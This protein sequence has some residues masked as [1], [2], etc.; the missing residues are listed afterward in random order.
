MPFSIL[1]RF[2]RADVPGQPR[3]EPA[4]APDGTAETFAG[5]PGS[6]FVPI[7]RPQMLKD[8]AEILRR[9]RLCYGREPQQFEQDIMAVVTRYA[10]FVNALPATASNY[11]S[12]PGGLFRLGL[13]TAF[14][15]LQATDAQIFEGRGTI[16]QRRHLEPRWRHATF[17]AGLCATLQPTL[18]TVSVV[19]P[20]DSCWPS[21]LLPLSDWLE[22]YPNARFRMIW[23]TAGSVD[24]VQ[25][26]YALPH[27]VPPSVLEY[28]A[29]RNDVVVPTMLATLSRLPLANP[30]STMAALV[31]RAAVLSIARE[32]R[33]MA[34]TQGT[35]LQGDHLGRLLVDIMHDLAHG[36]ASWVPNS[37]KAR[38]WHAQDG[39][40]VVWPGAFQ[41]ICSYADH[42]RLHGLPSDAH[43]AVPALE[44]AGMI[45]RA[46][47]GPL[48]SLRPAGANG[49]LTGLK[50]AFPELVL[51]AQL[52]TC[53]PLPPLCPQ[54]APTEATQSEMAPTT[55]P[56]KPEETP[57]KPQADVPPEQLQ[58]PLA[59]RHPSKSH[60]DAATPAEPDALP[61]GAPALVNSMRL[62]PVIA[63]V[64]R[65]AIS[66]LTGDGSSEAVQVIREGILIPMQVF[67]SANLD[68]KMATRSL[69]DAGMLVVGEAGNPTYT[70][71][72]NGIEVRGLVLKRQFV[73]G[74]PPM[75]RDR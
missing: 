64:L 70:A 24:G 7:A 30:P 37:E 39:T 16:T 8:S 32:L 15:S 63:D 18:N 65:R 62:P 54:P 34:A 47:E 51:G 43:D 57:S 25:N 19:A 68:A 75:D 69:R 31:R 3:T 6:L 42:E 40:Y 14:F 52:A 27:V 26:L 72:S 44:R 29:E 67:K 33:R 53:A 58:L 21:Y 4:L 61:P 10:D 11:Y 1:N 28:L 36:A 56:T 41:D 22:R 48:W 12:A 46:Q 45:V 23:R 5:R 60:A 17:I 55:P 50:L 59:Q 66:G 20:D 49:D 38:L 35:P 9:I 2:F 73:T 13:D 74:L 71:K